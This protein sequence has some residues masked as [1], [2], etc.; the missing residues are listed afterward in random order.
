MMG[1]RVLD[2]YPSQLKEAYRAA[3]KWQSGQSGVI[4]LRRKNGAQHTTK[5][6]NTIPITLEAFF[7]V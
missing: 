5:M 4:M 3:L 2:T 7:S 1:L 6:T